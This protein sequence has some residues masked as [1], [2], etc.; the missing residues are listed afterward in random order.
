MLP[1]KAVD[2]GRTAED[3]RAFIETVWWAARNG[4]AVA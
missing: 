1:G 4:L 3:S 2:G